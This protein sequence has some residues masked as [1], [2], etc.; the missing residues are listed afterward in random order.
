MEFESNAT[1]ITRFPEPYLL[2]PRGIAYRKVGTSS[3]LPHRPSPALGCLPAGQGHAAGGQ[4]ISRGG[5]EAQIKVSVQ[6]VSGATLTPFT[7]TCPGTWAA[8]SLCCQSSR[9]GSGKGWCSS[10][11]CSPC[12]EFHRAPVTAK[13]TVYTRVIQMRVGPQLERHVCKQLVCQHD[14]KPKGSRQKCMPGQA[15]LSW[16]TR[17]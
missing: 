3:L 16:I 7:S 12:Q 4:K 11:G 2:P 10:R 15:D 17:M 9:T 5:R 13:P 1:G 14:A 6:S 8:R